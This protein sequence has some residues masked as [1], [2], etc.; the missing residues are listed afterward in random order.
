MTAHTKKLAPIAGTKKKLKSDF[1]LATF[2]YLD[3]LG[4]KKDEVKGG[5]YRLYYIGD[6]PFSTPATGRSI[7]TSVSGSCGTC[8]RR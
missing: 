1:F 8:F 5:N 4:L 3:S 2:E 7:L 6:T